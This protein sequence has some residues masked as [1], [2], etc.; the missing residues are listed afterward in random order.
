LLT[1]DGSGP[2]HLQVYRAIRI[3]ILRGKLPRGQRLPSSRTL[4]TEAGV[5]RNTV[6]LAYAQLLDEG[7]AVGRRGSGTY[8]PPE[9]PDDLTAI[10]QPISH[11]L[12]TRSSVAEPRLSRFGTRIHDW[13]VRWTAGRSDLPYDFRYG[14]PGFDDFPHQQ[15]H[16]ILVRR[17]RHAAAADLDYSSPGGAP[18]L[19]A[20]IAD[21][22]QRSRA[23]R[24]TPAQ[25][26]IVNGSQQGLDLAARVLVDA[27][28]SVLL[29]EPHYA[30]ARI[31]FAAAGARIVTAPVDTEGLDLSSR[32]LAKQT[33]R[34]AYVTPSHQFPTGVI[35]SLTRRLALLAWAE[36][37]NA[38]VLEDDYDSEY[39]YAGRPVESLQGLDRTGRVIYLG[40]FSKLMFPALRIGYLVLSDPLVRPFLTAKALTDTGSSTLEQLALADFMREGHFERHIRRSRAR[41][42]ARRTA[43]LEAIDTHL[44]VEVSG[45]NAGLHVL[46]WFNNIRAAQVRPLIKRAAAAGVGV[47][48]VAPFYTRAP[49]RAGLLL[50]YASLTAEQ[51]REG[52]RRLG[53]I[54]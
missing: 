38:Y 24:C 20:A 53:G 14:R 54:V 6:L 35:M 27:G 31:V 19:R 44:D 50:G 4:A 22:L 49:E 8:V 32:T 3:A 45:A 48:S 52:I 2:L 10:A 12:P 43:L 11:P 17:A 46:I 40:T 39:R 42:A 1:L 9:L 41:N 5:S 13:N 33:A 25:I 30:G 51:I 15:W 34:L 16:R 37:A 21:Y 47:Y 26:I 7:Y 18:E 23:V 36:R 28:A 29:E